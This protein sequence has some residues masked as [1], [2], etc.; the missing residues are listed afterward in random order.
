MHVFIYHIYDGTPGV[1]F[2]RGTTTGIG[3]NLFN[4]TSD[5]SVDEQRLF[6][7][8]TTTARYESKFAR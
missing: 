1:S 3:K 6:G 7:I 2:C 4:E 8:I 5:K